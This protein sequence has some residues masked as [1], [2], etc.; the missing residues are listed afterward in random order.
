MYREK[1]KEN[2]GY[3]DYHLQDLIWW[4]RKVRLKSKKFFFYQ[5]WYEKGIC[6]LNDLDR[7]FNHVKIF[8]DLVVEFD[9][10]IRDRRKYNY[11]L[12]GI[13]IDWFYNPLDVQ[14]NIFDKIV[15]SLFDNG[16][17]TKYSYNIMKV[18]DSPIDAEIFWFRTLNMEDDIDWGIVHKNNFMCSIE[19]QLRAFYFKVFHKTICTNKFLNKIGRYDSPLCFFCNKVDETLDHLFCNCD[20]IISLWDQLQMLIEIKTGDE[21]IFSN[22]QKMFGVQ[23]E[24]SEHYEAINFLILCLKFYIYRCKFQKINPNFQAYKNL[25]KVKLNTEYKIAESRDKLSKHFKKFSFDFG[26]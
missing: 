16:K 3:K 15:A 17:I 19:T 20:N 2:L 25:V 13:S 26:L 11:L 23:M 24:D 10:S 8:E 12:N 9:I 6:T 4:N 7:G 21:F 22:F 18:Q 5:D 1:I 14:E